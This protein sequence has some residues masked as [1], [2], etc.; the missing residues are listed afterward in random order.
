MRTYQSSTKEKKKG[1]FFKRNIYA[2]LLGVSII[3]V[4]TIVTLALT[5]GRTTPPDTDVVTPPV[6]TS[7]KF[8]AP[9]NGCTLSKEASLN[10][11][12]YSSTLKQWITHNGIDLIGAESAVVFSVA[13]GTVLSIENSLLDGTVVTI[14]HSNGFTSSYKSLNE[15]VSVK[16][17]DK[18][19][20]GAQIG[21]LGNS[22]I[23]EGKEGAHLHLELQKNG[24]FVDPLDHLPLEGI[25]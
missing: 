23:T 15:E 12:V 19:A 5:L 2:I 22:M 20:A 21:R 1:N 3:A 18:I 4:A 8:V 25:K 7:T 16:V 10:E 6:D 9:T 13:D 24:E 14:S 17:G 11:L